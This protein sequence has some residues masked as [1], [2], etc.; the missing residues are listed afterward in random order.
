MRPEL[1][2]PATLQRLWRRELL[3]M[4]TEHHYG[5]DEAL[6]AY[7]FTRWGRELGL[8]PTEVARD[9]D[10]VEESTTD[11]SPSPETDGPEPDGQVIVAAD[12]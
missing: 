9:G 2:E 12:G 11:G 4:L 6:A 3:P 7:A 5:N 8:L 10:D 1:A